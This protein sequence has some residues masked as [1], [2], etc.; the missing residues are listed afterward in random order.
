VMFIAHRPVLLAASAL[1]ACLAVGAHAQQR[2]SAL[3]LTYDSQTRGP[4]PI[5]PSERG[6]QTLV[7]EP[8]FKVS[9]KPMILEGPCFDRGGNLLFSDVSGGPV[10]VRSKNSNMLKTK[11]V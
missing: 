3:A 5:P 4:V 1:F 2:G 8:W 10:L 7:A 9:D 6:L 11:N